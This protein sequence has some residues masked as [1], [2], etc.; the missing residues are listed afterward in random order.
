M[1]L[2]NRDWFRLE[3]SRDLALAELDA[4]LMRKDPPID[5][6][7]LYTCQILEYAAADGTPVVNDPRAMRLVNE[8]TFTQQ[9]PQFADLTPPALVSRNPQHI[10]RFLEEHEDSVIKPLDS[11]GGA[12]VFRL[13]RGD[14]NTRVIIETSTRNGQQT[15]MVQSLI[16][17]FAEGDKRIL[18]I[19]G[20][21]VPFA[22]KRLP[23][24]GELRANLAAGGR[25]E[26]VELD[27]RDYEIC[28]RL[29]PELLKLDLLF[30]GLDVIG[31][32][33]TEVNVTSPTCLR[34]LNAA[35]K[36]DIGAQ[37]MDAIEERIARRQGQ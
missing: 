29:K 26:A 5:I 24:P 16:D 13:R 17:A 12:S 28:A 7:F 2:D 10:L 21:P 25:G 35:R 32:Y 6:E 19:D 15:V 9:S 34:E 22:L 18:V 20:N 23:P 4:I 14:H 30:V 31:G 36:L 33:L 3:D 27:E 8:K 11:M 1:K 37:V